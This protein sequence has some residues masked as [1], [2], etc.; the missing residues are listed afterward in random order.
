MSLQWDL[1]KRNL[2][3]GKSGEQ[4]LCKASRSLSRTMKRQD[5]GCWQSGKFATELAKE[6]GRLR[7]LACDRQAARDMLPYISDMREPPI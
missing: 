1:K 6:I 7:S 3:L 4:I 2:D 5:S